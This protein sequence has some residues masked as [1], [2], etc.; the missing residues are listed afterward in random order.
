MS[1]DDPDNPTPAFAT[2]AHRPRR[3]VG[4][5]AVSTLV[6]VGLAGWLLW[7]GLGGAEPAGPRAG[8]GAGDGKPSASPSKPAPSKPSASKSPAA[9]ESGELT[10]KTIVIDPG[11]NPNN[12]NRTADI[13]RLVDIGTNKKECDTT[14]TATDDGYSEAEFT[15]DL[16]RKVRALLEKEGAKVKFTQDGDRPYGPCVDERARIGNEADADAV[17]SLHADGSGE[18]NRGFHVIM[19]GKVDAGAADTGEIVAPSRDLGER[20]AGSFVRTTGTAPSNYIG[21]GTG[22]DTRTDLGGLNLSK[23]PK[24]FLEC[25]NMR[26]PEDEKLLTSAG[27]RGKAAKGISSG[28]VDFLRK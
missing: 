5:V 22:L 6:P 2:A 20:I 26:D 8:A 13:A 7:S 27:W 9:G 1:Y 21:D 10:G 18:G 24:V 15:L 25:G 28:L 14:G 19:P 23:V 12:R 4:L 17:V 3:R 11:H 16:A